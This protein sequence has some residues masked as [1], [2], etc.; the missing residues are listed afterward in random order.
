MTVYSFFNN[1]LK[2]AFLEVEKTKG[3]INTGSILFVN[4]LGET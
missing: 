3:S 2:H 4:G 1:F